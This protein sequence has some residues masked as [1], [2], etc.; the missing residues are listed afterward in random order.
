M[1]L[2]LGEGSGA[3]LALPLAKA[4]AALITQMASLD[5]ALALKPPAG[6][7]AGT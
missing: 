7:R 4:A 5:A 6:T 3:A 1:G 2:R